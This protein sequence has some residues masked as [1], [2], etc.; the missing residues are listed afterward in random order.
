MQ[1]E[2]SALILDEL[3]YKAELA[4]AN[5]EQVVN[6]VDKSPHPQPNTRAQEMGN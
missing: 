2:H 4:H 3:G 5:A 1:R 6:R